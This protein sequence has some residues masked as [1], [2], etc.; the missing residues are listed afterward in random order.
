MLHYELVVSA[1]NFKSR[2]ELPFS[3]TGAWIEGLGSEENEIVLDSL[4]LG[5]VAHA[6]IRGFAIGSDEDIA[7]ITK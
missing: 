3:N 1:L 6:R 2:A 7:I 4:R 5:L